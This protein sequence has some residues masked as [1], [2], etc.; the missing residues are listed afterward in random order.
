MHMVS[1]FLTKEQKQ[2]SGEWLVFQQMVLEHLDRHR[3]KSEPRPKP[4]T[5]Y[6]N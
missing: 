5:L 4:H 2:F 6:K 3:E 1:Q